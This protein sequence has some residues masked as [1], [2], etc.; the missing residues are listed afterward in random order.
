MF[1]QLFDSFFYISLAITFGLI[2]LMV[3]HFKNRIHTLEE[4]NQDLSELC[5]TIIKELQTIKHIQTIMPPQQPMY[6]SSIPFQKQDIEIISDRSTPPPPVS[7]PTYQKITVVDEMIEDD[8]DLVTETIDYENDDQEENEYEE[9]EE[10]DDLEEVE[11]DDGEND[12]PEMTMEEMMNNLSNLDQDM[13]EEFTT[14]L[15]EELKQHG[16]TGISSIQI[17]P[18]GTENKITYN[19][20]EELPQEEMIAPEPEILEVKPEEKSELR[21][22]EIESMES[23]DIHVLKM[24]EEEDISAE[25]IHRRTLDLFKS[26]DIYRSV[27]RAHFG[28]KVSQ[29]ISKINCPILIGQSSSDDVNS[30]IAKMNS[31]ITIEKLS[32]ERKTIVQSLIKFCQT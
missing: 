7:S 1:F 19:R 2:L 10:L 25:V 29:R 16:V 31:N 26:Y 21:T 17:V 9:T 22:V 30:N 3:F 13:Y 4:K 32:S 28:Y 12:V 5:Q 24:P 11:I 6:Q 23:E 20:I 8:E 18:G 27:Y 14:M 15:T